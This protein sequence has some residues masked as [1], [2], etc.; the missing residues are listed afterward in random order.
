MT[1]YAF[2]GLGKTKAGETSLKG[3]FDTD[4]LI[5]DEMSNATPEDRTAAIKA[6][7]S[8]LKQAG[9][10][11]KDIV[12]NIPELALSP[13]DKRFIPSEERVKQ[14][15]LERPDLSKFPLEEWL[16]GTRTLFT[17]KSL[18][19]TTVEQGS[20]LSDLI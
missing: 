3:Y 13:G 5:R 18:E 17:G 9:M 10:F 16:D 15:K 11:P 12:T 4:S 19:F 1:I 14:I 2:P 6:G 8:D 7:L 20:Y